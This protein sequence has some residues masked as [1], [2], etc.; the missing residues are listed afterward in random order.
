M[1]LKF[2]TKTY[3]ASRLEMKPDTAYFYGMICRKLD[4]FAR[5][6]T[7]DFPQFAGGILVKDL[8]AEIILAWLKHLIEIG[9]S[10]K[11]VNSY[12]NSLLTLWKY[13]KKKG[14]LQ[15]EVPD[16][17]DLPRCRVPSDS[18]NSW[19]PEQ[20][21]RLLAACGR[22]RRCHQVYKDIQRSDYWISLILFLYDTG[23][24]IGAALEVLPTDIDLT[25]RLARLRSGSAKTLL[26]QPIRISEQTARAIERLALRQTPERTLSTIEHAARRSRT[27]DRSAEQVPPHP[28]NDGDS[29]RAARFSRDGATAARPHV[30]QDDPA[31]YRST[32][33]AAVPGC[34]RHAD[35]ARRLNEPPNAATSPVAECLAGVHPCSHNPRRLEASPRLIDS[36]G[37]PPVTLGVCTIGG[38]A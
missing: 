17:S 28:Q 18:P 14:L 16:L 13:A 5:T 12:R 4:Q 1:L 10:A 32:R 21:E 8:S 9:R 30:A 3:P 23:A 38:D 19:S 27:A 35:P 20:L 37:S 2:A 22:L 31:V 29:N 6:Q 15:T 26:E 24:R 7:E 25:N 36:A 11:T 34:R 33:R